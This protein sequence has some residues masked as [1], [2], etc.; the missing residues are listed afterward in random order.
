M[1]KKTALH[2]I[3]NGS[4]VYLLHRNRRCGVVILINHLQKHGRKTCFTTSMPT[5]KCTFWELKTM[6]LVNWF[7]SSLF[8]ASPI[9]LQPQ[10]A[11]ENGAKWTVH[12]ALVTLHQRGQSEISFSSFKAENP[13]LKNL[14]NIYFSLLF[15]INNGP[16]LEE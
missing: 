10:K 15:N 3:F 11:I 6:Y 7:L 13:A 16:I 4:L 8:L 5:I 12:F 2:Y 1:Y 9:C 14:F